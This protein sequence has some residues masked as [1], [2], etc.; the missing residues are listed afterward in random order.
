MH[1]SKSAEKLAPEVDTFTK[2]F[3]N[4]YSGTNLLL[5]DSQTNNFHA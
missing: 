4:E 1:L 2:K 5:F 3:S